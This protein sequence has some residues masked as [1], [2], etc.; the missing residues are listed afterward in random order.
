MAIVLTM[1]VVT[2]FNLM[3]LKY[4]FEKGR[5][6]DLILDICTIIT[7]TYIFGSTITGM[8]V[9]MIASACMSIYLWFCPPKFLVD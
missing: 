9:A 3:I 7:L 8:L 5:T 4:K 1:G 6:G 2:F